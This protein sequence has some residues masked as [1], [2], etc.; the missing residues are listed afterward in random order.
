MVSVTSASRYVTSASRYQKRPS[1]NIRG[2][3]TEFADAVPIE[4]TTSPMN[5]VLNT[6]AVYL[7]MSKR[8][9]A[10]DW[11]LIGKEDG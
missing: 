2:D 7:S 3:S 6:R 5:L 10:F 4:R 1:M 8:E 11:Q 9:L